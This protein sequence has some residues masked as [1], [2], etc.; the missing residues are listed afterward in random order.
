MARLLVQESNGAREFELVDLE[1]AIGRE[2]DNTLRLSDPSISRHHAVIRQVPAG[3]EIHDLESSNGVFLN[4]A[5]VP[6]ALLQDGDRVLLG[7]MQLT[8]LDP[9]PA[10]GPQGTVRMAPGA[11]ARFRDAMAAAP[12]AAADRPVRPTV[13]AR[14]PGFIDP[15]LP[16]ILDPAVPLK[17]PDGNPV[18]GDFFTRLQAGLIDY[19]PM[20]FLALIG[21]GIAL[22]APFGYGALA[23]IAGWTLALLQWILLLAYL[24]LMP[25]CWIH[26]GA[27]PGKKAMRLR[28]VPE[29]DPGGRIDLSAAISRLLGYLVMAIISWL[30][31]ALLKLALPGP[32]P[33]TAGELAYALAVLAAGIL[34]YLMILGRQRKGLED[35]FSRSM[36]IKVDR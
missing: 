12:A 27:T 4:G 6:S 7:Q 10:G 14:P 17:D 29:H 3:Y 5:R 18:R 21:W 1:V 35:W 15:F 8:F 20:L 19:S 16:A 23:A 9:R 26:F 34:P 22:G 11:M 25:L 2:L 28:V 31:M 30:V 24:V 36:V 13:S 32:G 33:S